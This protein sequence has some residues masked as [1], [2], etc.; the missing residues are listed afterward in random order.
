MARLPG[1]DP[2]YEYLV[3]GRREV[4]LGIGYNARSGYLPADERERRIRRDFAR[5]AEAGANT[6]VGWDMVLFDTILLDAAAANG[7]GVI[8]SFH[9]DPALDYRNPDVRSHLTAQVNT[10]VRASRD[11]PAVRM[12]GLGNEVL[13]KKIRPTWLGGMNDEPRRIAEARAF[14]GF[15]LDLAQ[16]VHELDPNHPVIYRTAESGYLVWL[17]EAAQQRGGMPPNMVIGTNA[18]TEA[19][20]TTVQ[21]WPDLAMGTPLVVTEFG[22]GGLAPGERSVALRKMWGWIRSRPDWVLGGAVYV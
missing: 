15:L 14:A 21:E 5:M 4:L 7:L 2:R 11:H 13:R 10:W 12:W 16:G 8:L 19:L 3:N 1:P 9:L 18:Y 6:V 22:A 20:R 17:R